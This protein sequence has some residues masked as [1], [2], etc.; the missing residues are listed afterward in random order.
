MIRQARKARWPEISDF[1]Q[2][3]GL[4]TSTIDIIEKG[5]RGKFR[6]ATA[7]AVEDA[8]DWEP[9]SFDRVGQGGRP[10]PRRDPELAR[11]QAAW[12]HLS[13]DARKILAMLAE[14]AL[15]DR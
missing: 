15:R 8:L 1:A 13:L 3:T 10:E 5:R 14:T 11:V 6:E 7:A 9:G 2:A 4:S 12:A